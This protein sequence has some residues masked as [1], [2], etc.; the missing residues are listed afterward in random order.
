MSER[1]VT[2]RAAPFHVMGCEGI[3][4]STTIG[5]RPQLPR[6]PW[7]TGQ[8]ITYDVPQ[9]LV[10]ALDPD[11]PG[12]LLPM[13]KSAA[14][15][16]RADLIEALVNAGVD[17]LQ[18]FDAVLRDPTTGKEHKGY[19]AVNVVGVVSAADL[20]RSSMMGTTD[21]TFV[22]ADFASLAFRKDISPDLLLFRLAES[23]NAI[24]VHDRVKR[25]VES[26]GIPGMTFY[27][28]GE[29]SG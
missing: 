27:A 10:Y 12:E 3:F 24:V 18:L 21:S 1:G 26:A 8:L 11:Y 19:K 23:V 14:P 20:E 4:P 22:D 28:S 9:P 13:Y 7:M 29:W 2:E 17:N 25:A 6:G 15:L 5:E 16:M